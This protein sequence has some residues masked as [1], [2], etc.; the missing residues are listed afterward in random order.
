MYEVDDQFHF[1]LRMMMKRVTIRS[2]KYVNVRRVILI[3][4]Q[5]RVV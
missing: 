5:C 3:Q 4:V 1:Q 2:P